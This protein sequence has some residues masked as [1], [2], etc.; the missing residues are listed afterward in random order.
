[1]PYSKMEVSGGSPSLPTDSYTSLSHS[2]CVPLPSRVLAQAV[3]QTSAFIAYVLDA[4]VQQGRVAAVQRQRQ[5]EAHGQHFEPDWDG[6]VVGGFDMRNF[7]YANAD[8]KALRAVFDMLQVSPGCAACFFC[9]AWLCHALLYLALPFHVT[10]QL[11]V[12]AS[13]PP[14]LHGLWDPSKLFP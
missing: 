2:A 10:V 6:K 14:V 8:L 7:G 3:E 12:C 11:G 9:F 4:M 1:M 13:L 5:V